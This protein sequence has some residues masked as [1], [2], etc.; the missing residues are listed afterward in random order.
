LKEKPVKKLLLLMVLTPMFAAGPEGL[1]VWKADDLRSFEKKLAPK[2]NAHKSANEELAKFQSYWVEIVHREG[3]A[4]AETHVNNSELFF[5][6]SGEATEIIGGTPVNN[7][8]VSPGEIHGSA[9][10]G[11]M[12]TPLRQGDVIRMPANTPHQM[13]VAAGKQITFMVVK[14]PVN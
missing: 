5:I 6:V 14:E 8:T 7:K 11:G 12:R 4:E 13:L 3:D 1:I 2:M 9:L 10:N